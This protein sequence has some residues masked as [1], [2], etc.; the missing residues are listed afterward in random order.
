VRLLLV[1]AAAYSARP[2]DLPGAAGRLPW[3]RFVPAA[4][5]AFYGASFLVQEDRQARAE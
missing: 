2:G 4:R 5:V 3:W 1:M